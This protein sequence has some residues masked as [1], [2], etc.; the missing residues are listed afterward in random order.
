MSDIQVV[1]MTREQLTALVDEAVEK[2]L[3]RHATPPPQVLDSKEAG[4]VIGR[5][6]KVMERMARAGR[7][8]AYRMGSQWRFKRAEIEAW[9]T[10]QKGPR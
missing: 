1:T 4:R 6:P 8:P 10:S 7:I 9:A 5:S 3:Q 2:A